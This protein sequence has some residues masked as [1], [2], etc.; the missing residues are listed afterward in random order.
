MLAIHMRIRE[1]YESD[2]QNIAQLHAASWRSAYR[3]MLS[4]AYLDGEVEAERL[5]LW[6]KRFSQL[7]SNQR[8][9]VAE[10]A[11]EIAGFAC[12]YG[13][14]DP[15]WGTLL[16]N[17]H[18]SQTHK[19]QGVGAK[20]MRAVASWSAQTHAGHG[21]YLWVLKPNL[22]AQMFYER[23]GAENVGSD[24]WIP[25][26]GG[27]IPKFRF[28]WRQAEALLSAVANFLFNGTPDGAR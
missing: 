19:R 2:T 13:S 8:V 7:P 18:V 26:D 16:E 4:D 27:A 17:I 21:I 15:L 24:I 23:L 12:A 10:S 22:D 6:R 5:T 3:G 9:I 11:G 1:A 25:P 28:A 14:N 20:L